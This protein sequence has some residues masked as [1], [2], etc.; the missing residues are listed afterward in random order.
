MKS[1]TAVHNQGCS[2]V[3]TV[4]GRRGKPQVNGNTA[5]ASRHP[6]KYNR[7]QLVV[8]VIFS[9]EDAQG[10][11][12]KHV[13]LTRDASVKGVCV[14]AINPPP[15]HAYINLKEVRLPVGQASPVQI[16]GQGQVVRVKPASGSLPGDFA[17]AAERIEFRKWAGDR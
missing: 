14:L 16:F 2:D 11:R 10:I 17:V 7:Y 12:Q 5:D 15:L 1:E 3:A 6:R 13:G 4:D 8:P 9:W